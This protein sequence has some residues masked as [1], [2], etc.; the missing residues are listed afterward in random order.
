[1]RDAFAS[2]Q[3]LVEHH[4]PLVSHAVSAIAGRLPQSVDR[5][6]LVAAGMAGLVSA[7]RTFGS[8]PRGSE[9]VAFANSLIRNA[10]LDELRGRDRAG[11]EPG[12]D[13]AYVSR[14]TDDVE[15][16]TA[17]DYGSVVLGG[18]VEAAPPAAGQAPRVKHKGAHYAAALAGFGA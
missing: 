17:I 13:G 5:E 15:R 9:F 6:G 16:A 8:A 11:G 7:A 14:L 3:T 1:M 2:P 18:A 4:L 10:L 12:I